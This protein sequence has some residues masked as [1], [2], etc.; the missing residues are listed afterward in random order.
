MAGI[1]G[2]RVIVD[3]DGVLADIYWK[4]LQYYNAIFDDNLKVEDVKQW[5]WKGIVK[6][7]TEQYMLNILN[8]HK[9]YRDLPTTQD[10]KRVLKALNRTNDVYIVTDYFTRMSLK[11]KHDWILENFPFINQNQIVLTSSKHIIDG[12]YI[13]D[14]NINNLTSFKGKGLLFDSPHNRCEDHRLRLYNIDRVYSWQHI[15]DYF[16]L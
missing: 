6:E 16:S 10:S 4:W 15:S 9:F 13:I 5:N 7:G 8:T 2:K 1:R 14:D 12:D 3:V 11:S